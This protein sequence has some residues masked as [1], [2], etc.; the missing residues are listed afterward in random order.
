LEDGEG[1]TE[2]DFPVEELNGKK[3]VVARRTI[4]LTRMKERKT[5][6]HPNNLSPYPQAQSSKKKQQ[7]S[8]HQPHKSH[9]KAT[10]HAKDGISKHTRSK[11]LHMSKTRHPASTQS[12]THYWATSNTGRTTYL[13]EVAQLQ[14]K[15]QG[16]P[17]TLSVK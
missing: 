12:P 4:E 11:D 13:Q 14:G 17:T 15:R 7:S 8:N 1:V 9:S 3:D 6:G 2:S 16:K 5:M 10:K